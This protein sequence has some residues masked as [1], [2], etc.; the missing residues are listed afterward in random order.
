MP[1]SYNKL[2]DNNFTFKIGENVKG[3]T[4]VCRNASGVKFWV[5]L[6]AGSTYT[7]SLSGSIH[8]IQPG[9]S[10]HI[11]H[12]PDSDSWKRIGCREKRSM[13]YL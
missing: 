13:H 11:S 4:P 12:L 1:G 5:T 9:F 2:P 10:S 7:W 3:T 8:Y 6:T